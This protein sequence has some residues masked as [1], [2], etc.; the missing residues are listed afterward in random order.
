MAFLRVRSRG[1]KRYYYIVANRRRGGI[2]RQKIVEYLG[3]SPHPKRLKRALDYWGVRSA[4]R[5][6]GGMGQ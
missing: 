3:E 4:K 5:R 6:T 1:K 2:V